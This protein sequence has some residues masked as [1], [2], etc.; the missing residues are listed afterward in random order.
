[1]SVGVPGG[2]LGFMKLIRVGIFQ[3]G[4]RAMVLRML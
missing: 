4:I 3:R 1:M 2:P